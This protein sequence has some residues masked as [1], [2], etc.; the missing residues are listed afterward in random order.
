MKSD[1]VNYQTATY[2]YGFTYDDGCIK[3]STDFERMGDN[4]A[5]IAHIRLRVK[6]NDD[7]VFTRLKRWVN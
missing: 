4:A 7:Y 5:S 3:I 2:C 1:Y 6:I